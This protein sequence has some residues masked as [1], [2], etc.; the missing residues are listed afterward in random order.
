[1]KNQTIALF[2][3]LGVHVGQTCAPTMPA[4]FPID[5]FAVLF[6]AIV[7]YIKVLS[8]LI[9]LLVEFISLGM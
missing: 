8:A 2:E 4:N 5:L 1:M 3:F 9:F 6:L 7:L